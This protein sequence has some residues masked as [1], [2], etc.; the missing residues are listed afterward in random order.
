MR[1]TFV[2]LV[3]IRMYR[4]VSSMYPYVTRMLVVCQ[5]YVFVCIRMFRMLLVGYSYVTRMYSCGVLVMIV[6]NWINQKVGNA[7][8]ELPRFIC[9]ICNTRN[10]PDSQKAEFEKAEFEKLCSG[11]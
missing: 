9:Q 4:Y 3:C 11:I 7:K 1:K 6:I 2:L 8:L 5:S 10:S